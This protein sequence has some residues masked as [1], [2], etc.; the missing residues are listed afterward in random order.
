MDDNLENEL[1]GGTMTSVL[2]VGN[3]VHRTSGTWTPRVHRLLNHLRQ[4]GIHEIPE[5]LGI[6]SQGREILAFLPGKA[7]ITL[8]IDLR[9][10]HVLFQASRLLRR[11]HDA[12]MGIAR[13]WTN[14]W[15]CLSREPVEVICHG[16]YAPY[17][18]LF[19]GDRLTGVIDFDNA[20]PGPRLWDISYAVYRFA[21]LTAPSNPEHFGSIAEQCRRVRLFCDA[22]GLQDRSILMNAVFERV[23]G[24]AAM[25]RDGAAKGDTRHQANIDAGHLAI[26]EADLSHIRLNMDEYCRKLER[27]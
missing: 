8:T 7:A 10:N 13:E 24:M 2:R 27:D 18:C 21:P 17:N 11:M 26:Y 9:V 19:E 23:S 14:G 6:D 4:Q 3:T 1:H 15:Q 20:H 5:P 16:D 12:T 25:L 22:Y